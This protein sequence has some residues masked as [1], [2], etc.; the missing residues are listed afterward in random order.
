VRAVKVLLALASAGLVLAAGAT[1]ALQTSWGKDQLRRLLVRL[2]NERLTASLSIARLDGSLLRGLELHDVRLSRDGVT[3]ISVAQ[4]SLS[5][6]IRDLVDESIRVERIQ[7]IQ[8]RIVAA[9]SADGRWNLG[10]LTPVVH[11]RSRA[12]PRARSG[13]DRSK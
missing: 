1:L 11:H 6:N 2:A 13:W 12:G 5:Y 3:L 4:V 9:R 8:P 7:L 10:T